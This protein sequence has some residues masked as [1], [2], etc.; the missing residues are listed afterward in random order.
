MSIFTSLNRGY[1]DLDRTS[2]FDHDEDG[3]VLDGCTSTHLFPFFFMRLS[4][5]L[6]LFSR[7][8]GK[9]Q[10]VSFAVEIDHHPTSSLHFL[11]QAALSQATRAGSWGLETSSQGAKCIDFGNRLVGSRIYCFEL[12]L[13]LGMGRVDK[14]RFH[15]NARR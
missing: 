2:P 1:V 13:A 15:N 12:K 7:T 11:Q 5:D 14:S 8:P 3:Q 6:R 4:R 9:I 10:K